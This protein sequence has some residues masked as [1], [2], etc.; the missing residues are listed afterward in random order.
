M[1]RATIL[2]VDD[3]TEIRKLM[4]PV[5]RSRGYEVMEAADGSSALEIAGGF[6]G[7]IDVLV[8]DIEMPRMDGLALCAQLRRERPGTK[9]I[10]ISGLAALPQGVKG[11]F[12]SKPFTPLAL[13]RKILALL[14]PSPRK[15]PAGSA[16]PAVDEPAAC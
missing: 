9:V 8:T 1:T 13:E 14:Q 5:L 3:C 16:F 4:C 6:R 15:I 12:L 11:E 10:F 7:F 2:F